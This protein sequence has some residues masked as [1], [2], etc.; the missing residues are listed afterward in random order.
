VS[1]RARR[2]RESMEISAITHDDPRCTAACAVYNEIAAVLLKDA[3]AG[4]ALG[5]GEATAYD[6]GE[7]AVIEAL[8]QAY[9]IRLTE[10]AADGPGGLPHAG[11]GYVLDSLIL[12]VAALRDPR[13]FEEIVV[14]VVRIG[15]DTDTNASI[16]GGLVGVRDGVGAIPERWLGR[17]QFRD[18]FRAAADLLAAR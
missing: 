6:L 4:T 18:E 16:A 8:E 2:V 3:T 15:G 11:R 13:P 5:A 1:R 10:L 14:D 7:P 17:L 12:A 9:A